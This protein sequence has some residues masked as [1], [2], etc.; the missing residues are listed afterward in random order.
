[1]STT[2]TLTFGDLLRRFRAASGMTQEELGEKAGLSAKGIGDLERGARQTPRRETVRLLAEAL[3]LAERQRATFEAAARQRRTTASSSPDGSATIGD[4]PRERRA[5]EMPLIGRD[6]E[7]SRLERHIAGDGPPLLAL[8]GEPGIGKSRLLLEVTA[9]AQSAGW[10]I[11]TGGCHRRSGQE[12]YAPILGLLERHVNRQPVA[13]R[14]L[15][16]RGCSW[17]V[18]LLPELAE[19]MAAP[20]HA[21]GLS[22]E[23]ERRLM[24]AAVA[25]YLSN[26]AGPAG[27]LLALDDLQWA[28]PDA[29]DLLA[30]LLRETAGGGTLRVVGAFRHTEVHPDDPLGM[31]LADLAREN[32]AGR[33]PLAP[34]AAEDSGRL[35]EA[36]LTDATSGASAGSVEMRERLIERTGGVPYFLVSYVQA[37]RSGAVSNG[38]DTGF[39]LPWSVAETIRQ[40]VAVLPLVSK[41]LLAIAATSG[42]TTARALLLAVGKL[43][44]Y[45][46]RALLDGLERACH[47]RLLAEVGA[48]DYVFPH[49][50]V[51]ETVIADLSTARRA[52]LHRQIAEAMEQGPALPVTETLAYHYSQAGVAEKAVSYLEA[53]GD[54]ARARYAYT[55]ALDYYSE[56]VAALEQL[57]RA[58]EAARLRERQAVILSILIRYDEAVAL[59][60]QAAETYRARE[61]IEG[62]GRVVAQ[63]GHTHAFRGAP[64]Q[65]I[66]RVEPMLIEAEALGLSR[67]GIAAIS[68]ALARLYLVMGEYPELL[69]ITERLIEYAHAASDERA[70]A[71]ASY[72]RGWD[73]LHLGRC[74]EGVRQLN[75]AIPLAEK[76]GDTR[77]SLISLANAAWGSVMM[78]EFVTARQ[79]LARAL[80]VAERYGDPAVVAQILFVRSDI[81]FHTGDWDAAE[82]DGEFA[83]A[84]VRTLSASWSSMWPPY[85]LGQVALARNARDTADAYFQEALDLVRPF[86]DIHPPR[87]IHTTLAERDL[88]DGRPDQALAHLTPLLDRYMQPETMVTAL[89]PFLAW[90]RLD[91]DAPKDADEIIEQALSRSRA[92]RLRMPL[93]DA[94]RVRAM[95]LTR[96]AQWQPAVDALEETLALARAMSY[97]YAEAKALYAYGQLCMARGEPARARE[98]LYAALAILNRL[99]ERLYAEHVERLLDTSLT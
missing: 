49:D 69:T 65:G 9:Q 42:R 24:F 18:R 30:F 80:P 47:G 34:L 23:Q 70:L 78:G 92:Q 79:Y 2:R 86:G 17:L 1:M 90:A 29:L 56:A 60:E 54:R 45:D 94:L 36:L 76:V 67:Q 91:L 96:R 4:P 15:Y 35:L 82:A 33:L 95:T 5:G 73:L 61:D 77:T 50:L 43:A 74:E 28:A 55:E 13:E 68:A 32:L 46:D 37:L 72:Y 85:C 59:L 51:R 63:L 48:S 39:D 75:I 93:V 84:L 19:T 12:P 40:R 26:V 3:G 25:R 81:A 10:T 7:R 52:L 57:G 27:T 99:G 87:R 11:L 66:A 83:L 44:G 21:S 38:G 20:A 62:L 89:L 98:H 97:P 14:R 58:N 31:L 64:R 71:V 41:D 16:L 6:A 22:V 88:L 8:D 53:A